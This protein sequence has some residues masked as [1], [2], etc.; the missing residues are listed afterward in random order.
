MPTAA[1]IA[2]EAPRAPSALALRARIISAMNAT[3][4]HQRWMKWM[5]KGSLP[6]VAKSE[7]SHSTPSGKIWSFI[8]GQ[9]LET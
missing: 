9:V 5:R 1:L 3:H 7:P 2:T 4:A 8:S 6:S